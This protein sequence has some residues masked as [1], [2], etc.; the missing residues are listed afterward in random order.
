VDGGGVEDMDGCD[1]Q[2]FFSDRSCSLTHI[3]T[4]M[5]Y[6]DEMSVGQGS[7]QTLSSIHSTTIYLLSLLRFGR[8]RY[9]KY[10]T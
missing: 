3:H 9:S 8:D 1:I 6:E 7:S 10:D 4:K 2:V 5:K